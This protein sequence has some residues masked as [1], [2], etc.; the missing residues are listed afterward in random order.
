[1]SE[2]LTGVVVAHSELAASLLAAVSAIAG[3]DTGLVAVSNTGCDR[4]ALLAGLDAAIGG[5]PAVVFTDMAGGSCAFTAAALARG[6]G[7]VRVVTGVNLA[8]LV[9]FAF[10]R[11]LPVAE[12][13]QRAVETGRTAVGL[14]GK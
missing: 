14:V 2:R 7:D 10:H 5:R 3:D 6:R 11:D 13:A 12:A 9:D 8:M 1:M 4:A